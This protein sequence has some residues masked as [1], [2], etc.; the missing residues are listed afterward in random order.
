MVEVVEAV[1]PPN[2]VEKVRKFHYLQTFAGDVVKA[3]IKK[4]NF[5]KQWRQCVGIVQ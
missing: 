2:L 4:D 1:E 5:V 3:D